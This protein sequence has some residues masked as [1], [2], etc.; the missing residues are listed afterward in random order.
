MLNRANRIER[1][2][3]DG[4]KN[5]MK[6]K[7]INYRP[8]EKGQMR[9]YGRVSPKDSRSYDSTTCDAGNLMTQL[10]NE[11]LYVFLILCIINQS[12]IATLSFKPDL[13][14][15]C[16]LFLAFSLF[17]PF[18]PPTICLLCILHEARTSLDLQHLQFAIL[19]LL[20]K[21]AFTS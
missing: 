2:W 17:S 5:E 21:V 4:N 15:T 3:W 13:R 8:W 20:I 9:Q 10:L 18:H 14:E 16:F 1:V 11:K 7:K 19:F 12:V 6:K